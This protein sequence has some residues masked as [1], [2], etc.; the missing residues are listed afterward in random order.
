MTDAVP[1][2]DAAALTHHIETRYHARH[3][4]QLPALAELAAKVE[5]VH[6]QDDHAPA[7]LFDLLRR[8]IG[9]RDVL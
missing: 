1:L 8:I 3:R 2:N 9:A 4:V 5:A 7:G 6:A